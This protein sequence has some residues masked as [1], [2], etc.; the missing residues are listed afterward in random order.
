MTGG[1]WFQERQLSF[2]LKLGEGAG[3]L[4]ID[5]NG[6]HGEVFTRRWIVELILD[7]SGYTP[8]RDLAGM[9][10]LEPSCG[11]GAFLVPMVERLIASCQEHDRPLTDIADALVAYDLLA[12]NAELARKALAQRLPA[13]SRLTASSSFSWPASPGRWRS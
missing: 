13:S 6:E 9:L 2:D 10:A 4:E 12:P 7:L 8:D 3:V 5:E 11:S 1:H